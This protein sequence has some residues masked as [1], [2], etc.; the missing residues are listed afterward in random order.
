VCF[1]GD[2]ITAGV[3]DDTALGWV[4]RVVAAA[5]RDGADLTGYNLGVRGE[6]GPQVQARWLAEA[7]VRLR[8]G[9]AYGVVVAFGVNDTIV[10]D[11]QRR[12]A[13]SETLSAL[14]R[15]AKQA[16]D[17]GWPL[18][19]VG[20]TL[21]DDAEQNQRILALSRAMGAQCAEAGLPFVDVATGLQDDEWLS[22]VASRDGAHPTHRGYERLSQ[23]I[24]PMFADW[25][26]TLAAVDPG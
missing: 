23:V 14:E 7:D 22:E 12:A 1:F 2:S 13:E 19:A 8:R 5:R 24:Y 4:G 26:G 3:G 25:L 18:L 15:V 6:T 11:G 10:E 16:D 20:P 21:V 9:D 17:A